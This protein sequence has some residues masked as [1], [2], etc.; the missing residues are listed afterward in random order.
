M[1]P[2]AGDKT[3]DRI[4]S[5]G[6]NLWPNVTST[7]VAQWAKLTHAAVLYHFPGDT[8][9]DA[10]AEYAVREGHSNVIVQLMG[11]GHR[12]VDKLSQADRI[13]HFNAI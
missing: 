12:A 9:Q 4:L 3:R 5:A 6:V 2:S 13:R 8:L 7:T 10:V 1:K 11:A